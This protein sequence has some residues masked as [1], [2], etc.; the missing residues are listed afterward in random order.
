MVT[1][2]PLPCEWRSENASQQLCATVVQQ[3]RTYGASAYQNIIQ[4]ALP[5]LGNYKE[6]M[7]RIDNLK[8]SLFL[9]WTLSG[10]DVTV[11]MCDDLLRP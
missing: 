8:P 9:S 7:S 10:G 11:H 2:C 6:M 3:Q 1:V 5:K 4:S